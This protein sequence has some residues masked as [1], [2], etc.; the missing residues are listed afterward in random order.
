MLDAE[1]V[2]GVVPIYRSIDFSAEKIGKAVAAL[3]P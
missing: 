1:K 3:L 2:S